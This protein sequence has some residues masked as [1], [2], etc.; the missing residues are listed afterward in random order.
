MHIL[1]VSYF[2]LFYCISERFYRALHQNNGAI[3]VHSYRATTA[4]GPLRSHL[5]KHHLEEWVKE[6]QQL[7]I[8]LRGKEGEEAIARSTGL[9]VE[10]QARGHIPFT[11]DNFLDGLVQFIVATDQVFLFFFYYFFLYLLF[12]SL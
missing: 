12:F 5:L 10:R 2:I 4:T 8:N 3:K 7:N 1:L 9:P 11:Q 6:C